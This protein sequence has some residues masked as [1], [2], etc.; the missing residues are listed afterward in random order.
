MSVFPSN[1]SILSTK[2][3]SSAIY[4]LHSIVKGRCDITPTNSNHKPA[5]L[6]M[7][8]SL[9]RQSTRLDT[10]GQVN[11][12][13]QSFSQRSQLAVASRHAPTDR[14]PDE[15]LSRAEWTGKGGSA[16]YLTSLLFRLCYRRL[17]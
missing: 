16:R 11:P 1:A 6:D 9:S 17:L 15:R 2:S 3:N 5:R 10:T 13:N 4:R 7:I 12:A 14:P 8:F